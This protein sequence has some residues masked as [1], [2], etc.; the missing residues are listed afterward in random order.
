LGATKLH[1]C[2]QAAVAPKASAVQTA[3]GTS[4][5]APRT[6]TNKTGVRVRAVA[7]LHDAP[8][9]TSMAHAAKAERGR[10]S[11]AAALLAARRAPDWQLRRWRG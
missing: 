5:E 3:A 4:G 10:M 8:L 7:D 6:T 11:P 9:Q 2:R 1:V